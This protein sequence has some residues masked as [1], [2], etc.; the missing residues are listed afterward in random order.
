MQKIL[1]NKIILIVTIIILL[2]ILSSYYIYINYV[3]QDDYEIAQE[4][5]IHSNKSDEELIVY[6]I[7]EVIKPGIVK[8]KEGDR[9]CDAI[10]LAGG[11][12][13]DA[14]LEKVNLAYVLSDGLK[15]NI[16]KK[17][18][19][20]TQII[21]SS[22]GQ[23]IIEGETLEEERI[24]INLNTATLVDLQKLPGIGESTANKIIQYRNEK[25]KFASTNELMQIS[26]IGEAKFNKLKDYIYV[27]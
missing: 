26:G 16:P 10:E 14:D 9:I 13:K 12:T 7:G 4:E 15:I 3:S 21:M 2:I 8:I 17:E 19:E 23:N 20:N 11:V 18:E 25:G 24:Y 27:K 22:S 5:I 6:I 1:N